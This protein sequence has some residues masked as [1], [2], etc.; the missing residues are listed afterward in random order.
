VA[1][2]DM[3]YVLQVKAE[4]KLVSDNLIRRAERDQQVTKE[5][6]PIVS[7]LVEQ[8][9]NAM[10]ALQFEDMSSQNIQHTIR[11]L[12][13][14]IPIASSLSVAGNNLSQLINELSKYQESDL[15][16]QHN[17]V[18]ASSVTSGSIDLF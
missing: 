17:P 16:Q 10:R 12:E 8:L 6:E 3:T 1:S 4:M 7:E 11:R 13:E 2:Q 15:R 5:M 18:S 14:L 9:H